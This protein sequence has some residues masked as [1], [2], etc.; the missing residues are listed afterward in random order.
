MELQRVRDVMSRIEMEYLEMPD[1]KL[2]YGQARRLF[3]LPA[4]L[5]DRALDVLVFE[6]VLRRTADGA[7]LK[8]A[9]G[10][11]RASMVA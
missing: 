4:E 6:G 11:V 3:G 9:I 1:L 2:T 8:A 7:F 10:R 5:C